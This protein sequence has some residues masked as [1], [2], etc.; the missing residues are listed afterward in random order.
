MP[1]AQDGNNFMTLMLRT[2]G[3]PGALVPPLRAAIAALDPALPVGQALPLEKVAS[4]SLR[5]RRFVLVLVA[6][7]GASALALAGIGLFGVMSYLVAQRTGEIGVRLML[8]ARPRD[9]LRLVVGSGMRLVAAGVGL[10]LLGG[11]LTARAFESQLFGVRSWDPL[12]LASVAATLAL[13]ALASLA[14]PA[15]RAARVAPA[16]AMRVE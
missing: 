2:G 9:V 5:S 8:G 14:V 7:F 13:A 16:R 4:D 3:S 6:V 11:L 1:H 12:A 10:G 15:W